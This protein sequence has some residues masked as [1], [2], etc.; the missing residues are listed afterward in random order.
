MKNLILLFALTFL[1]FT[2]FSQTTFTVNNFTG[3]D[4]TVGLNLTNQVF[5]PCVTTLLDMMDIP[6]DGS[7]NITTSGSEFIHYIG[8]AGDSGSGF[9]Y[10]MATCGLDAPG[11]YIFVF[12]DWN[13]V[14]IY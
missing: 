7:D 10:Y 9:V 11:P 6:I 5:G 3:E 1:S 12:D 14:S 13:E 4:L 2:G 8:A